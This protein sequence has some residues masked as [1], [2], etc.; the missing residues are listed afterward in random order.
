MLRRMSSRAL[1]CLL[2]AAT[3]CSP[4][5]EH[6]RK[7][8][9]PVSASPPKAD[10][11]PPQW[12][13]KPPPTTQRDRVFD[14]GG[15]KVGIITGS[16]RAIVSPAMAWPEVAPADDVA[17]HRAIPLPGDQGFLFLTGLGVGRAP[18]FLGPITSL[19]PGSIDQV[20]VGPGFLLVRKADGETVAVETA[21]GKPKKGLPLG[22]SVVATA[23]GVTIGLT[24]FGSLHRS[25]DD[26]ST[27]KEVGKELGW[28]PTNVVNQ[29]GTV[30]VISSPEQ[31]AARA[32]KSGFTAV[33]MPRPKPVRED[34]GWRSTVSPL[35]A[36]VAR[37]VPL[38]RE[39][40]LVA[41]QGSIFVV[42]TR[43]G[44]IVEREA[45]V[46][47][48]ERQCEATRLTKSTLFL[49]LGSQGASVFRRPDGEK[50]TTLEQ[51]F[52]SVALFH[53]GRGDSL[54]FAGA[55]TG[56]VKPAAVCVRHDDGTWHDLDRAELRDTKPGEPVPNISG[57]VP[58]GEG[59]LLILAAP[60]GGIL[61]A[62]TGERRKLDDAQA[63]A[64]ASRFRVS[65]S[66]LVDRFAVTESGEIVGLDSNNIGVRI[67]KDGKTITES[68]FRFSSAD[69]T[70]G[71]VLAA[72]GDRLWQSSDWGFT[73]QEVAPPPLPTSSTT[74]SCSAAGCALYEWLRVGWE[75]TPPPDKPAAA[76]LGVLT[77]PPEPERPLPVIRCQATGPAARKLAALRGD[78]ERPGL[79]ATA[80]SGGP[81]AYAATF[82]RGI[83]SAS[84]GSM[85]DENLRAIVTGT[86]PDATPEGGIPLSSA[87]RK[88]RVL[89]PFD[90]KA[91]IVDGTVKIIDL[92]DAARA[93]GGAVPDLLQQDERGTPVVVGGDTTSVL[94]TGIAGPMIW[95]RPKGPPVALSLGANQ[96]NF[97]V[98]SAMQT[99]P[100]ELTVL[101][102]DY[103]GATS[104]QRITRSSVE[105]LFTLPPWPESAAPV[106]PDALAIGPDGKVGVIRVPARY[107][108]TAEQPAVLLTKGEAPVVLA[109]WSTAVADGA[110]GCEGANGHR[111]VIGMPTSWFR[112]GV[113]D[114]GS[115]ER[116]AFA[117]VRWSKE[118]V[119]VEA[120]ELPAHQYD[121]P[122]GQAGSYVVARFGKDAA[123][124]HVFFSLGA[125]LREPRSCTL[126]PAAR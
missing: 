68:P 67:T 1:G 30:I 92:I 89:L 50:R 116:I 57:I 76:P 70:H 42:S 111:A 85:E 62:R 51:T 103:L 24:I 95:A 112:L 53:R 81:N 46:L 33:P 56:P 12:V 87:P 18:S 88:L 49:C 21:T 101:L 108:P 19:V 75:P 73:F 10:A 29:D 91:T 54:L 20:F 6:A 119:C 105:E 115:S 117:R 26:G 107:A 23:P 84:G 78:A 25:V 58:D 4:A 104:I 52:P 71:R 69:V 94:L 8:S 61:D 45:G 41:D 113:V 36:A 2:F 124:M 60:N 14:L 27:W 114:P 82:P 122:N 17:V 55:C 44:A 35:E 9:A 22:L 39:R 100:D 43:T 15:G 109:P 79:G 47:P 126:E 90:P 93:A 110:P 125:E 118:R 38:D 97:G 3:A 123:A 65:G 121:L 59:A 66:V 13:L 120:V 80:V 40:A 83:A 98:T 37:G 32:D 72:S 31:V 64:L 11:P 77:T 48:P 5:V 102:E 86:R 63:N 74:P 106:T 16:R 96:L 28:S 99:G 34:G 7:P